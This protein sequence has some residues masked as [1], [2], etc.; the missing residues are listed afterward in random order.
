MVLLLGALDEEIA[1]L[2]EAITAETKET[3]RGFSFWRGRIEGREVVLAK[4]GVGKSLSALVTQHLVDRFTP[5]EILFCGIA[6]SLTP[7]LEIG[8]LLVARDCLQHD[9]DARPVGFPLGQIPFTPFRVLTCD[10]SLVEA[11]LSFTPAGYRVISGR[12]LTGDQFLTSSDRASH[13][14]L[15]EELAGDA[16]EMEGASVA[17]VAAVNE[18]PF[19]LV[20]A[21][22]DR[23]DGGAPRSFNR[24]LTLAARRTFDIILHVLR[25]IDTGVAV[26]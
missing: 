23:A 4:T 12:V 26:E 15:T 20:R 10:G 24:F 17:L 21:I 19:L 14:Y 3:W 25:S 22:S 5:T 7:T 8:D 6:G 9:M 13:R 1:E 16:V 11:A 2:R 18:I